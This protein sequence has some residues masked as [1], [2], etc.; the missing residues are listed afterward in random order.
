[1]RIIF[2]PFNILRNWVIFLIFMTVFPNILATE[3]IPQSPK[4]LSKAEL[5]LVK[6][7]GLLILKSGVLANIRFNGPYGRVNSTHLCHY[8]I[9]NPTGTGH[10]STADT[11]CPQ[12][13]TSSLVQ[14]FLPSPAGG[15]LALPGAR[16]DYIKRLTEQQVISLLTL[17][18]QEKIISNETLRQFFKKQAPSK[19][20][21][22]IF[23][24]HKNSF[25]GQEQTFNTLV[26]AY[27][28]MFSGALL[29]REDYPIDFVESVLG[30]LLFMKI[31]KE[32][33]EDAYLAT[34]LGGLSSTEHEREYR[35]WK[36]RFVVEGMITP[37]GFDYFKK[38][39]NS[40]RLEDLQHL[41]RLTL[42][43][44]SYDSLYP[45]M[46]PEGGATYSID[47]TTVTYASCGEA[48]LR[49]FLNF[50]LADPKKRIFDTKLLTEPFPNAFKELVQ[51]FDI[52]QHSYNDV[53]FELGSATYFGNI[54]SDLNK[55]HSEISPE[56]KYY[57]KDVC[58]IDVGTDN[59]LAVLEKIF[60][61][62]GLRDL[63]L[64]K[65]QAQGI[66]KNQ[67]RA[68]M[69][70]YLL[71]KFSRDDFELTWHV[72]GQNKALENHERFIVAVNQKD[73][74]EW[75]I[76]PG[77]FDFKSL[78]GINSHDWRRN[79]ELL[80][81]LVKS[82]IP[83]SVKSRLTPFYF[84]KNWRDSLSEEQ[85]EEVKPFANEIFYGSY[86]DNEKD[87]FSA[88]DLGLTLH[89]PN[90]IKF[91]PD[92]LK[93]SPTNS[94][95]I[96][97]LLYKY[98]K[99]LS[100][101][102]FN[103]KIKELYDEVTNSS[104][105]FF[106]KYISEYITECPYSDELIINFLDEKKEMEIEKI[107]IP[108]ITDDGTEEMPL[109]LSSIINRHIHLTSYLLKNFPALLTPLPVSQ[110][111]DVAAYLREEK[112]LK[113]L[114][115][116]INLDRVEPTDF[117]NNPLEAVIQKE[118]DLGYSD[119]EIVKTLLNVKTPNSTLPLFLQDAYFLR[120]DKPTPFHEACSNGKI[121]VVRFLISHDDYLKQFLKH[122]RTRVFV[123][124]N[125]G[126]PFQIFDNKTPIEMAQDRSH[127]A[128]VSII[129]SALKRLYQQGDEET[130]ELIKKNGYD[131][132]G[133]DVF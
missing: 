15:R 66:S 18:H 53:K 32:G 37:K 82:T 121:A 44:D 20:Q 85:L 119:I 16:D 25:V 75:Y 28:D 78:A 55:R 70:T 72:N 99:I 26:K 95:Q 111:L 67:I 117:E 21:H 34:L 59:M 105:I 94:S 11:D 7:N 41:V 86:M 102:K 69:V 127:P 131:Q 8:S 48:T 29:E 13:H 124:G 89:S 1:M 104:D 5:D 12:D 71:K 17:I 63:R 52:I 30:A 96:V 79:P 132:N 100:L 58:G 35:E 73:S 33:G 110:L 62:P 40:G 50:V 23:A 101:D 133:N 38:L 27:N 90:L 42:G 39:L 80:A 84:P 45:N 14:Q 31:S 60:Q 54:L 36:E 43:Y 120:N 24:Q 57:T 88:F 3:S 116:T 6:L 114:L 47:G 118:V 65:E 61:D 2:R 98:Q 115:A 46:L 122:W 64:Q 22:T 109:I 113:M 107:T 91:L 108:Y 128:I 77:H 106:S 68:E 125:L 130:Q 92:W 103:E 126:Q 112:I 81:L 87:K 93:V 74:F 97:S 51:F 56:I 4:E 76:S 129:R 49:N 19:K 83:D 10:T 123:L 9:A